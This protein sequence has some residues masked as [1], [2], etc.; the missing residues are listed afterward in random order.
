MPAGHGSLQT[1]TFADPTWTMSVD[2]AGFAY[3]Q[4]L[5]V[6]DA[7]YITCTDFNG[8]TKVIK[9][10]DNGNGVYVETVEQDDTDNLC[11][12]FSMQ[13]TATPSHTVFGDQAQLTDQFKH[14]GTYQFSVSAAVG[15]LIDTSAIF[16][17]QVTMENV[18]DQPEY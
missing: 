12:W 15:A 11:N 2:L 8:K 4:P 16:Q 18:C 13:H 6:I 9:S 3:D 5:C 17:W 7:Y 1:V 10:Q 14:Y